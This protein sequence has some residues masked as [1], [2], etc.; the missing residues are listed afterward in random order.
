MKPCWIQKFT[1]VCPVTGDAPIC[2]CRGD[3]QPWKR[4]IPRSTNGTRQERPRCHLLAHAA[5]WLHLTSRKMQGRPHPRGAGKG[6]E[7]EALFDCAAS[8]TRLTD[9]NV[10][11]ARTALRG[12]E[13]PTPAVNGHDGST[14]IIPPRSPPCPPCPPP[15]PPPILCTHFRRHQRCLLLSFTYRLCR[16][17]TSNTTFVRRGSCTC[18]GLRILIDQQLFRR[19]MVR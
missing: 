4:R 10:V 1:L 12:A 19:I 11:L 5:Q 3:H 13:R 2:S 7:E 17:F 6:K 16:L 15:P 8:G 18:V 14:V 9:P